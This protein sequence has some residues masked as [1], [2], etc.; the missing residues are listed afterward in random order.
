[1]SE[2]MNSDQIER[3]FGALGRIEQK[4][5]SAAA[6]V[7]THTAHDETVQKLLFERIEV[8]QLAHAKQRGFIS[9]IAAVASLVSAGVGYLIEK[10]LFGG[11]H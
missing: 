10:L 6:A 2:G 11:H 9:A 4:I 1:M 7:I 5:D 3:V 8:L